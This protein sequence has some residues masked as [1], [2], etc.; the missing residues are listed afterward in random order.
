MRLT[1]FSDFTHVLLRLFGYGLLGGSIVVLIVLIRF[2]DNRPDLSAWHLADL[3]EEF[4]AESD[5]SDFSQYLA[6]LE[7][8]CV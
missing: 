8:R 3:D 7:M 6:Y 5:V 4:T 1:I 2:L